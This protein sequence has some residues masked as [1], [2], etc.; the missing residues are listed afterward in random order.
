MQRVS[1]A[2]PFVP[3][4][5]GRPRFKCKYNRVFTYTPMAT[6]RFENQV[7]NYYQEEGNGYQ[8]P[9]G[10]PIT[11]SIEFGMPIPIST[12]K[13]KTEEMLRGAIQH[14]VKP[15]LDNLVKSILDALNGIAWY[16]D[17]Q[18]TELHI[19]KKYVQHPHI[20]ITIHETE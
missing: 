12:S 9:K 18:I 14:T 1:M 8:F 2:M 20:Y 15:D 13:K 17:A 3:T 19:S 11:V 5:K 16:D 7:A 4:P 10:T 6:K